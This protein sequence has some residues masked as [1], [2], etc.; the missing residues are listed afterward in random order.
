MGERVAKFE[1]VNG[2][3]LNFY[4]NKII[5]FANFLINKDFIWNERDCFSVICSVVDITFNTDYYNQQLQYTRS[6]SESI[7]YYKNQEG[8]YSM[9]DI[10]FTE[11]DVRTA[12]I[13][14][15]FYEYKNG[16]E[17]TSICLGGNVLNA[18]EKDGFYITKFKFNSVL[19]ENIKLL[20]I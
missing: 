2:K 13:G 19:H 9:L 17:N 15:V 18:N 16:R 14:D 4:D 20:G 11:K 1:K 3:K 5:E 7:N 8:Y 12:S 6:L 10:G